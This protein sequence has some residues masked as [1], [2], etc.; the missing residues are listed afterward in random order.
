MTAYWDTLRREVR[1][2]GH[3][4][5]DAFVEAVT[6]IEVRVIREVSLTTGDREFPDDLRQQIQGLIAVHAVDPGRSITGH[7]RYTTSPASSQHVDT[8]GR[9]WLLAMRYSR[10]LEE[11]HWAFHQVGDRRASNRYGGL[12][13]DDP[14]CFLRAREASVG[15]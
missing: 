1:D 14:S 15:A 7:A 5:D 9:S 2:L 11:L 4:T 12:F 10:L 13:T 3:L 6:D 8:P